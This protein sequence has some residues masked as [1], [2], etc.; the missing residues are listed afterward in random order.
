MGVTKALGAEYTT[1][2]QIGDIM[3]T[4]R[5]KKILVDRPPSLSDA[6]MDRLL[7]EWRVYHYYRAVGKKKRGYLTRKLIDLKPNTWYIVKGELL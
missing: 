2:L 1:H 5:K 4:S 3:G 7:D 6:Q